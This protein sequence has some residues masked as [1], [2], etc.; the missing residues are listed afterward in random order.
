MKEKGINDFHPSSSRDPRTKESLVH[1]VATA[2][3]GQCASASCGD[4]GE[5]GAIIHTSMKISF[6]NVLCDLSEGCV[7]SKS[8]FRYTNTLPSKYQSCESFFLLKLSYSSFDSLAT[9]TFRQFPPAT[10]I[11]R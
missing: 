11:S 5:L 7:E 10:C 9:F 3:C 1:S 8:L 2:E 4:V 6:V